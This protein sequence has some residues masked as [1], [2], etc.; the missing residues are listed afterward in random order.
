MSLSKTVNKRGEVPNSVYLGIGKSVALAFAQH[1]VSKLALVDM[2]HSHLEDTRNVL[3]S[4]YPN[5]EIALLQGDVTDELAVE[6][7]IKHAAKEFKR[8]DYGVNCAGIAG[9]P[10]PTHETPLKEWQKIID[11]NQTGLWLCHKYLISQMMQQE[12]VSLL[13]ISIWKPIYPPVYSANLA[14][15][16]YIGLVVFVRAVA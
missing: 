5:V 16:R 4:K 15:T 6:N 10:A 11:I 7:A 9:H 12:Y 8:I 14:N 13:S 3:K 2:K 1:G